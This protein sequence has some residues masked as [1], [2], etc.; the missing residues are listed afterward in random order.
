MMM[1]Q[2]VDKNRLMTQTNEKRHE[3]QVDP[4]D[5]EVVMEVWV[6]DMTFFDVQRAAQKMF[7]VEKGNISFDLDAYW[8]Y[9]FDNFVTRTNP[10]LSSDEMLNLSAYIGEQ[11][12]AHLPK[13]TELAEAIQGDFTKAS[14]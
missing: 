7:I 4:D 5:P 10:H 12:S 11:I 14:R 13:P 3:I 8:R 6:R 1:P 2:I 9:A